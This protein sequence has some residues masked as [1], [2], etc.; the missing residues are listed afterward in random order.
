M[1]DTFVFDD[2][3]WSCLVPAGRRRL[4]SRR[5]AESNFRRRELDEAFVPYS[6]N[7]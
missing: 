6:A 1:M 2:L 4:G 7:Q 5:K 3:G